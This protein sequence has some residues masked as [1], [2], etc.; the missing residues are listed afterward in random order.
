VTPNPELGWLARPWLRAA[1]GRRGR[2][3]GLVLLAAGLIGVLGPEWS[4]VRSLRLATFDAYQRLAPRVRALASAPAVIVEI[5]ERSLAH[6]GQW[7]W[8]RTLLA[9]LVTR[10]AEHNPAAIGVDLLMPEE[11]RL[12]PPRLPAVIPELPRD[13]VERLRLLPGSDSVLAAAFRGRPVVLGVAGVDATESAAPPAGRRVPMRLIGEDPMRFVRAFPGALRSVDELDAAAAGHGLLNPGAE[14][15]VV[16]RMPM[17]SAVGGVLVPGLGVEMLRVA[18]AVPG[19]TIRTGPRGVATVALGDLRIPTEPDGTVW[20]RYSPRA[21][22]RFV[23]AADVLAG[24][25]E[26]RALSRKLVLVGVTAPALGDYHATPVAP[27]MSGV[28]IHAQLLEG[29]FDGDLLTRPRWTSWLEAALLLAGGALLVLAVPVRAVRASVALLV[30]LA[31]VIAGVGALL[32]LGAGILLDAGSPVLGLGL[33]YSV[34]LGVTLAEADAQRRALRR[35]VQLQRE[36]AA[37]VAGELE[38]ARRIQMGIVPDAATSFPGESRFDL[39]AYLEPARIVG[40]DLYDFFRLSPDRLF[41][42][43]GDVSGKGLPGSLFMAVSKALCKSA[44]LRR[45]DLAAM[46]GEANHEIS[47][48]NPEA[49]FVTAFAGILDVETGA[50]QYV[51]AGHETP[52]LLDGEGHPVGSLDE[53]GGPPL[54]V[55]D[56]FAYRAGAYRM[57]PGETLVLVTDGLT[58]ARNPAGELYGRSRLLAVLGGLE[59][60]TGV[61]EMGQAIRLDMTRF[62]AEAEPSDDVAVLVLRWNGS[63]TGG[64]PVRS[65]TG[66]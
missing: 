39:A 66:P 37:R 65:V 8:P 64:A 22:E 44:A 7:P 61:M 4:P 45:A 5:D 28:E 16:R 6:H 50:L 19:V 40:G 25:L 2:P 34:L 55:V 36:A 56:E 63:G 60:A 42:L 38:A 41:F 58:E 12:S 17:V 9:R 47:R 15:E 43:V 46:M 30:G 49:L 3:L 11:D 26:S 29:I 20:L 21:P 33:L 31:A 1:T 52:V 18:T 48:D 51:N 13:V 59:P 24:G 10:I 23:S 27:R 62:V 54:C 53:G 35:Q 57:R 14:G 32:Y